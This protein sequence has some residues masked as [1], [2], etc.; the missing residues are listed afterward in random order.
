MGQTI[1]LTGLGYG[2]FGFNCELY[3]EVNVIEQ[4]T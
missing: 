2:D 1:A 3:R 4:L